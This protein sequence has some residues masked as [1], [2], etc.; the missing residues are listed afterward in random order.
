MG[1]SERSCGR[2]KCDQNTTCEIVKHPINMRKRGTKS[3]SNRW[4]TCLSQFLWSNEPLSVLLLSTPECD[5]VINLHNPS[6][7]FQVH[8]M[9]LCKISTNIFP[10]NSFIIIESRLKGNVYKNDSK[11][12]YHL[13]I[14]IIILTNIVLEHTFHMNMFKT[15][16]CL[17]LC[18]M[19]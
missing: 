1:R 7:Q 11:F 4:M 13:L 12:H 14:T 15:Y 16:I 10:N 3:S 5:K 18:K 17:Y 9:L 2:R 19:T 6:P 8:F